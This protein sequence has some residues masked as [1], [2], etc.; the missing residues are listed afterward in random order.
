M[1]IKDLALDSLLS[2]QDAKADDIT[3]VK[4]GDTSPQ[5][6]TEVAI[7]GA[8][9]RIGAANDLNAFWEMLA[10]GETGTRDLPPARRAAFEEYLHLRGVFH[11]ISEGDYQR[12]TFLDDIDNFDYRF[13]GMSKQEANLMDPNQR[14]FLQT[15][16]SAL[17]DAGYGGD[18]IRGSKTGVFCGYS[19]DFGQDYRH[20]IHT[21]APDAPEIAVAG[22]VK[23]IIASRLAYQMDL[24]GPTMMI[25]T[26]CSSGLVGVHLAL[27]SIRN[28]EC[29]MALAGA[30]K[31]DFLPVMDRDNTG[32]GTKD[33]QDT[34]A[35]DERTKTFD[36]F[37]DGTSAAEGVIAFVLKRYDQALADG[38][39]ILAVVAGSAIN[40]DGLS[41]GITAPNSDAQ[42]RLIQD[43]L[44]DA[45][46][47]PEQISYIEAHG[48]ATRLGDPIEVAGVSSAFSR[49]T[50]RKQFCA[51]GSVKTNIGH[52]DNG[53]GLAGLAKVIASLQH[54]QLPPSLNF[55]TPNRNIPFEQS[56]VYVNDMLRPWSVPEGQQRIAGIN[57]FGLSGTNCHVIVR[58][59]PSMAFNESDK[60]DT[61]PH[62]LVL[63]GINQ[64]ALTRQAQNYLQHLSSE[65]GKQQRWQ[66]ICFTAAVGRAHHQARLAIVAD[67]QQS[68]A[69]ALTAY[70]E[71]S[72]NA[73]WQANQF[74]V[75]PQASGNA[76]ELTEAE[77]QQLS[78]QADA[79]IEKALKN[80]SLANE[81]SA[82]QALWVKG[83]NP[84]WSAAYK[85]ESKENSPQYRRVSLPTYPFA[86][87]SC[88]VE[89][90][91]AAE[92]AVAQGANA[93]TFNHPLLDQC[94]VDS[95]GLSV[96]RVNLSARKH[97]EL[98]DHIVKG[99][100]VL[101][102][103]C[104]IEIMLQVAKQL[105]GA[106]YHDQP[107]PLVFER[108]QFLSPFAIYPKENRDLHIQVQ[109][110]QARQYDIRIVSRDD[111]GI[112][113]HARDIEWDVHAEASI[114]LEQDAPQM[115]SVNPV[116]LIPG[117]SRHL[118][119]AQADDV[120]RG[121]EIGDRWNHSYEDGWHKDD[122][123][124]FMVKLALPAPFHH[125]GEVYAWHPAL[126][127]V[128]VNAANHVLG[129]DDLY[130]PFSYKNFTV[131]SKMPEEVYV[132]FTTK[133]A[134]GEMYS[135]DIRLMD[136]KGNVCGRIDEYT[137][138]RVPESESFDQSASLPQV[139]ALSA[140]NAGEASQETAGDQ[141]NT[142]INISGEP[143]LFMHNGSASQ[144]ALLAVLKHQFG[145]VVDLCLTEAALNSEDEQAQ[146]AV[147]EQLQSVNNQTFAAALYAA[148]LTDAF[149]HDGVSQLTQTL[150][151]LKNSI[152]AL[153]QEKVLVNGPA[154]VLTSQGVTAA[155]DDTKSYQVE[156][157]QAAIAAFVRI[158]GMENPQ[159]KLTCLDVSRQDLQNKNAQWFSNALAAFDSN[160]NQSQLMWQRDN[161]R[162][163][164]QLEV[165][166]LG[167]DKSLNLSDD[168]V[169]LITGGTGALGLE[170]A[171]CLAYEFQ[172]QDA[173]Q[174][175]GSLKLALIGTTALPPENEWDSLLNESN[176][177]NDAL[178]TKLSKLQHIRSTGAE[179][180]CHAV[181]LAD[182]KAIQAL[183]EQL[184]TQHQKIKGVVHAAGRA[185]AGYLMNKTDQHIHDVVDGKAL[186]AWYLHQHTLND[187]LQFFV[188]YS[189]IATVLRNPGQS[190][191]TAANSFLDALAEYRRDQGLPALSVCWP[192]WRET[193][194]AVEWNAVDEDE[195]FAPINTAQA[196]SLLAR[197]MHSSEQLPASIVLASLNS[198]ATLADLQQ[199]GLQ[200]SAGLERY[201]TQNEQ[202]NANDGSATGDASDMPDVVLK[203]IAD[204]DEID[205]LVA[206]TWRKV[207]GMPEF[208]YEES[209]SDLGGNSILTTQLYKEFDRLH[210]GMIEMADLFS[211]TT[212]KSQAE[213]LK[214][215][216]GYN[217]AD[218]TDNAASGEDANAEDEQNMD[219]ILAKLA[220]GEL[221]AE[222]AQDLL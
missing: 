45:N 120:R 27:R 160:Q 182:S 191:Y 115:G 65:F 58:Q 62:L 194:I 135:F 173:N 174:H 91:V 192:A 148:T 125:E 9:V 214:K 47:E 82:L 179:V 8:S 22:N 184:R 117:F 2:K 185:G 103:T 141:E 84:N 153:V 112:N 123:S 87:E 219:D 146:N 19:A 139:F 1:D 54:E 193:G 122:M 175:T 55:N 24:R 101:P 18:S 35:A 121:L 106:H 134:S 161:T 76:Q 42:A 176:G 71:N 68:A 140:T 142:N 64:D 20:I 96:Y 48:T 156:P 145:D 138:K 108:V 83:A 107:W 163:V 136:T 128:A 56:P 92:R 211:N 30:V 28:N 157:D 46:L 70:L 195:F 154:F 85:Q 126:L 207:L 89:A 113:A 168:G 23:S 213:Q 50:Q 105:R 186:G 111:K 178:T 187:D 39:N 13:F 205:R 61:T 69:E 183:T 109:E 40:Q 90:T 200:A 16:W 131:I 216:L 130:L 208:D 177:S 12:E 118:L 52:M 218:D 93:K 5:G 38:D 158:A 137:V 215:A 114:R 202:K 151:S 189:S 147:R 180:S 14:L 36:D 197:A 144:R 78:Q 162:L 98:A 15:G 57:S 74:K 212:I 72:T 164:E 95:F 102:G 221:S 204:P 124:E 21:F 49:F 88:W 73:N 94:V 127:D 25:D 119:F 26:A 152:N 60:T 199:L 99:V 198:K 133:N 7:I 11:R 172:Q 110:K 4:T 31:I 3:L 155:L 188:M 203:S 51:I 150:A 129:E 77:Q 97:W 104:Y 6:S 67:S 75:V 210:P 165:L 63:S 59:A 171:E 143:I 66:D 53:A 32:V 80:H 159:L 10:K 79:L 209:F 149:N 132:W 34:I 190:D 37:S 33:I 100:C 41:V 217:K 201:L 170:L 167:A 181:D 17:E 220:S 206:G 81:L 116:D 29:D 196:L 86:Q 166:N 222:E 44:Q 43:A 169:Y